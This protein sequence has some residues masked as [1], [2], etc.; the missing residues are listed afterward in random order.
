[1][2]P[3]I[4]WTVV[5]ILRLVLSESF[6]FILQA[7]EQLRYLAHNFG[8]AC[9]VSKTIDEVKK[10]LLVERNIVLPQLELKTIKNTDKLVSSFNASAVLSVRIE[11]NKTFSKFRL[12]EGP[13]DIWCKKKRCK[14]SGLNFWVRKGS[15][16]IG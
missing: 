9:E 8:W 15:C 12:D 2:Q 14:K 5:D 16:M 3:F 1:M 7:V 4:C 6:I 11:A 13:K 10:T